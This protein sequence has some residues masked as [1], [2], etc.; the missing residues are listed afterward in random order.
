MMAKRVA[1]VLLAL[2][3]LSTASSS[4]AGLACK[5][6]DNTDCPRNDFAQIPSVDVETCCALCAANATCQVAV[7]ATHTRTNT[8]CLLKTACPKPVAVADRMVCAP[9]NKP[10]PPKPLPARPNWEPTY[11]MSLS[12]AIMPC[13]FSG[14]YNFD[15]YPQLARFGLIDYDWSNAKQV[16]VQES[17]MK[18]QTTMLEQAKQV[19]ARNPKARVMV[20]RNIVK[21]LPWFEEVREKLQ[22]PQYWGWFLH[23]KPSLRNG[24]TPGGNL[25]HDHMQTP[26][27]PGGGNGGPDGV[28]HNNTKPPWGLGCDCGAGVPCGE[29]LFDHRNE[30]LT[31][32]LTEQYMNGAD[33]GMGNPLVSGF[34]LDDRWSPGR[35]PSEENRSAVEDIGL[36]PQDVQDIT[37]GWEH[38]MQAC[39]RAL[40]DA[41]GWN[42]QLFQDRLGSAP[43]TKDQCTAYFHDAC[44]PGSQQQTHAWLFKSV[45][46]VTKQPAPWKMKDPELDL[47][48]FLLARGPHAWIGYGWLG[49]GCGWEFGGTLDCGAYPR[50]ASWD[51]DYGVPEGLCFETSTAGVFQ[52][53]WTKATVTMDCNAYVPNIVTHN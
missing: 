12:T 27:W 4:S 18:C 24:T 52:R 32:W 5:Y 2:L 7:F 50:P 13:N 31:A 14:F 11:N 23:W 53:N 37:N 46:S 26:G 41:G 9:S 30:S 6:T 3:T 45:V 21:A 42:W 35:G 34:Y 19:K 48:T 22:D 51:V 25:Y 10:P 15:K 40:V 39:Q 17:P 16:W 38:N 43:P 33:F 28:C 1:C 8:T 36:S 20:Y 44:Q 49:C 47:A 29:Y